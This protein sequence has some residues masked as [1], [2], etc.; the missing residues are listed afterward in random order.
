MG[1]FITKSFTLVLGDTLH[2]YLYIPNQGPSTM[3]HV[4]YGAS[5]TIVIQHI[6]FN[7]ALVYVLPVIYPNPPFIFYLI[8]FPSVPSS[9]AS[10]MSSNTTNHRLPPR[11]AHLHRHY[12]SIPNLNSFAFT[13]S[14]SATVMLH[15]G[16][17]NARC[18]SSDLSSRSSLLSSS[19]V[20]QPDV[21]DIENLATAT[22]PPLAAATHR[23]RSNTNHNNNPRWLATLRHRPPRRPCFLIDIGL[24]DDVSRVLLVD[25]AQGYARVA[26]RELVGDVDLGVG[27]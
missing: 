2:Y 16:D 10:Q 3:H 5:R 15:L 24:A 9:L 17:C 19:R 25:L 27:G 7:D 4:Y 20:Q 12:Q 13:R 22:C 11:Q 26:G 23:K 8:P 14:T 21:P 18:S 6:G 1:H